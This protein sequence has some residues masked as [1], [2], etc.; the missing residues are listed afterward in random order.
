MKNPI[1]GFENSKILFYHCKKK[2][3]LLRTSKSNSHV[4]LDFKNSSTRVYKISSFKN[5]I[6]C[7]IDMFTMGHILI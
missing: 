2:S 3:R 1:I 7:E 6:K 5:N 4:V